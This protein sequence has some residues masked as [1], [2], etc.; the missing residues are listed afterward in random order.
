MKRFTPLLFIGVL[1]TFPAHA[2]ADAAV[3]AK[4]VEAKGCETCHARQDLRGAKAIYLRRGRMV[5]SMDE[6]KA[7]VGMCNHGLHLGLSANEER[8]IVAFLN[9]TYYR[10]K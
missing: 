2:A 3:G 8:D 5:G 7:Q 6:L 10:F 1:A 9:E 4:L